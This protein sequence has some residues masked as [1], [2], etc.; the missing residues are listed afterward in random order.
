[1]QLVLKSCLVSPKSYCEVTLKTPKD[2]TSQ[3][4][5]KEEH[6]QILANSNR[7]SDFLVYRK[8]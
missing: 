5:L 1:M 3:I 4:K 8:I 7:V 2:D 6:K